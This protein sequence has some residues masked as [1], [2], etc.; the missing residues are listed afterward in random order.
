MEGLEWVMR[1]Y[2][3]GCCD[4]GWHY[5]YHYPP[6]LND[7]LTYIPHWDSIMIEKNENKPISPQTQ[8]AYVLPRRSLRL[9]P[10]KIRTKLLSEYSDNYPEN[11]KIIWSFCKYF[12]ESHVDLP[13]IDLEELKKITA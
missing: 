5:R 2:T 10:D 11:C 7:L 13:A 3:S 8:L 6:T 12:W 4:W 9:L 1:Y